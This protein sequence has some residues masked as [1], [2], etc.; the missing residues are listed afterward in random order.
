MAKII[1][2][3]G[4]LY[5]P[6]KV[7]DPGSVMAPPY[8]CISDEM[9]EE[10]YQANPFNVVRLIYGKTHDSDAQEDNRYTRAASTFREWQEEGIL[11]QDA[12][13]AIYLYDQK[14]LTED[15]EE[16]VRQGFLALAKL[17]EFS[18]GLIKPHEET[19]EGPKADRLR[20]MKACGA[21][22]CSIFSLY[23]DPCCALEAL[24]KK[25][26][27]RSPDLRVKSSEPGEEH[28]LWRVTDQAQI[29]KVQ[30]LLSGKPIFIADGHHR[31]ETALTYRD[32]MREQNPDYTGKELFNYVM[33]FFCNMEDEG[34]LVFPIHRLVSGLP[35]F[36][37]QEFLDAVRENFRVETDRFDAADPVAC[38]RVRSSLAAKGKHSFACYAGKGRIYFLTLKSKEIIDQFFP[39]TIP[40]V[41][42]VLDVSVLHRLVF[43]RVFAMSTEDQRQQKYLKYLKSFDEALHAVDSGQ[44]QLAFLMN[45]TRVTEV[46]EVANLGEKMPQK[47]TYFYPKLLSGMIFNKI[48]EDC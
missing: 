44:A 23:S 14:F 30:E 5:N 3:H 20:L 18:T 26:R 29:A 48:R 17:E 1:P 35:D 4:L 42:K 45:P 32:F 34:L 41:L 13:P 31:Y 47:S 27:E 2:F 10:L 33:M 12:E 15:G 16:V 9:Q 6:E 37:L 22:F 46:R 36:D 28:F 8:D 19:L 21:N 43:E 38:Q 24:L 40:K 11:V 39:D 7:K 25:N